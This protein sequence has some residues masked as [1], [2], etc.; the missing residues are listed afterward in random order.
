MQSWQPMHWS[1]ATCTVPSSSFTE[2]PAG[3]T[4]THGG[5]SQ[6]WQ[7]T[8]RKYMSTSGQL[9]EPPSTG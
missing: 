4:S 6:C 2:A 3:Q 9:P 8:F 7:V 1:A 5:F